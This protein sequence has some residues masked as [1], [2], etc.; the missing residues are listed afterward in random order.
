MSNQPNE[1]ERMTSNQY[2]HC[3]ECL[4]IS[5]G[6]QDHLPLCSP[7]NTFDS[8]TFWQCSKPNP[9]SEQCNRQLC[10]LERA[11]YILTMKLL[12]ALSPAKF[13]L[14]VKWSCLLIWSRQI[15]LL[16]YWRVYNSLSIIHSFMNKIALLSYSQSC[17]WIR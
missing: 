17:S 13:F 4:M 8:I 11:N 10:W 1:I 14:E 7:L 6:G 5:F 2:R 3:C 16:Y 12:K 9:N 15:V